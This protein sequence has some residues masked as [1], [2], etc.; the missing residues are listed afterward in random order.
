MGNRR[1]PH[2]KYVHLLVFLSP[3]TAGLTALVS[4]ARDEIWIPGV[5]AIGVNVLAAA[6]IATV[7]AW[8]NR[9]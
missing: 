6:V 1:H 4:A 9:A 8:I 2:D 5:I 7:V 3:L